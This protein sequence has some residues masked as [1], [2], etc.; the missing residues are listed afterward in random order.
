MWQVYAGAV[1]AAF[2]SIA[3]FMIYFEE[4]KLF[5]NFAHGKILLFGLFWVIVSWIEF[6]LILPLKF[7]VAPNELHIVA[8]ETCMVVAR[9]L[10]V[11]FFGPVVVEGRMN[12]NP[13]KVYMIVANHQ[14]MMDITSL[15][16]L[17]GNFSWVSK[18]IIFLIPGAGWLMKL[19]NY[20]PLTRKNKT[21]VLRMF[22][23]AKDRFAHGWSVVV[24]PQGTRRRTE[25]LPF[26]DGAFDLAV[27]A[28]VEILPV[29]II[30]PDDLWTWNRL[31]KVKLVIGKPIAVGNATKDELKQKAYDV[32]LSNL[33]KQK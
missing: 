3:V 32:V 4:K 23:L 9:T 6:M 10:H 16:F 11:L 13:D 30:I 5:V 26:K 33:P 14:T 31:G 1:V 12:V 20:V 24:F 25:F 8:H 2:I 19:A 27:D 7:V 15:Y 18:S 28:N 22:E 21:S 29:T 17:G